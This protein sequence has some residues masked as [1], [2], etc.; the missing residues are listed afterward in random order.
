MKGTFK[1][2]C[3]LV[4]KLY[5]DGVVDTAPLVGFLL[6][7]PMFN[8]VRQ[9]RGP[10]SS[11][12]S[13]A[14]SCP[15]DRAA[16]SAALFAALLRPGPLPRPPDPGTAAAPPPWA[17]CAAS[18]AFSAPFLYCVFAIPTTTVNVGSCITQT[19]VAWGLAYTKVESKDYLKLSIPCAYI[20][21]PSCCMS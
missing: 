3:Q 19:W 9:L 4:N 12:P 17:C 8:T 18:A 1:E 6:T 14:P 21:R 7:L 10:L 13:S 15:P 16:S 2:N 5:Y 20:S 11:R